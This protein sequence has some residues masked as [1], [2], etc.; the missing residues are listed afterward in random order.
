MVTLSPPR[1]DALLLLALYLGLAL[2]LARAHAENVDS[3]WRERKLSAHEQTLEN[4]EPDPYQYKFF[5]ITWAVEGLH[6]RDLPVDRLVGAGACANVENR[7]RLPK[8]R[9]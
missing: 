1:R 7:L 6:R 4:R 5:A 9:L 8:S 3:R 2:M